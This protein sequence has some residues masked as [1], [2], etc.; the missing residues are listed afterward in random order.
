MLGCHDTPSGLCTVDSA[1]TLL[2]N[3]VRCR[4]HSFIAR[5]HRHCA[6]WN[7]LDGRE[8]FKETD[9]Q[10]YSKEKRPQQPAGAI[11]TRIPVRV[12]VPPPLCLVF[13]FA[14]RSGVSR[15][16]HGP[17]A[18]FPARNADT[19]N[20]LFET[21]EIGPN[22]LYLSADCSRAKSAQYREDYSDK[23]APAKSRRD[24]ILCHPSPQACRWDYGI[25]W[26][27]GKFT[28]MKLDFSS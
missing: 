1:R 10:R 13:V 17:D 2:E 4:E 6:G 22:K 27:P 3:A 19:C 12:G 28:K 20:F 14:R 9:R 5:P 8:D 24:L 26:D 25:V 18:G 15:I 23:P 11:K 21:A 7:L 16:Q